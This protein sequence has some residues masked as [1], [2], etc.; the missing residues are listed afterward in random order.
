MGLYGTNVGIIG[1]YVAIG[2]IVAIVIPNDPFILWEV[3]VKKVSPLSGFNGSI[4]MDP[5]IMDP[6]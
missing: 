3:I 5:I 4:I 1:I 2:T 6:L